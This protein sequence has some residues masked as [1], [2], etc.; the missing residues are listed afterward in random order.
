[1]ADTGNR[2]F[3]HVGRPVKT[4]VLHHDRNRAGTFIRSYCGMTSYV[5]SESPASP[6]EVSAE[7]RAK[8]RHCVRC[9]Y[10]KQK[11]KGEEYMKAHGFPKVVRIRFEND[12][13]LGYFEVHP[14][15][16]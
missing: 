3:S 16:I 7:A 12:P 11:E 2:F 5:V 1:M 8:G 4:E 13:Q 14:Y 10:S 15:A 6:P 9:L